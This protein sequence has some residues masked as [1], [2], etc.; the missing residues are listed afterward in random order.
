MYQ[1]SYPDLENLRELLLSVQWPGLL[2]RH[3]CSVAES[4]QTLWLLC[5]WDSP[6]K[7]L[8]VG[9]HFLLWGIFQT[10][11]S[12]P[13]L[14]HCR[15]I[16]YCLSYKGT[17]MIGKKMKMVGK[18]WHQSEGLLMVSRNKSFKP[19]GGRVV[20]FQATLLQLFRQNF[21]KLQE[22]LGLASFYRWEK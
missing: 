19:L 2:M 18:S 16:L 14:L 11:E 4:C 6:G 13:G 20:P 9:C 17:Q 15:Q 8:G 22:H 1:A 10:Q 21:K 12:N 7:N 3:C 5:P